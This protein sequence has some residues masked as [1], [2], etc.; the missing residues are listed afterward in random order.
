MRIVKK[1]LRKRNGKIMLKTNFEHCAHCNKLILNTHKY[2]QYCGNPT[3]I[4]L[5]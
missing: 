5:S 4:K 2:C 1:I 3:K